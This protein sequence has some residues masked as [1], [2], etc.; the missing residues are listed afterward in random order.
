MTIEKTQ[1]CSAD[2]LHLELIQ[3]R[4]L[5]LFSKLEATTLAAL[6]SIAVPL[7]YMGHDALA[8]RILGPVHGLAFLIYVWTALQTVSGGG[9]SSRATA[10]LFLTAFVPFAGF[11]T[12]AF[13]RKRA[14]SLTSAS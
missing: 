10:R 9:W 6:V 11:T 1:Q 7:K 2:A 12:P 13:L 8:V 5:E 4:R 3:L 14:A